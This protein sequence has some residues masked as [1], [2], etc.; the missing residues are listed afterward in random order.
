LLTNHT[1]DLTARL[2]F[3]DFYCN[4]SGDEV[5]GKVFHKVIDELVTD[6]SIKGSSGSSI[7]YCGT[8][9][10]MISFFTG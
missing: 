8:F 2:Y 9:V 1:F 6:D 4:K 5:K 3:F 10:F 7:V